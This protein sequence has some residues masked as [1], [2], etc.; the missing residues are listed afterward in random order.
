MKKF[1][2]PFVFFFFVVASIFICSSWENF[3]SVDNDTSFYSIPAGSPV[4]RYDQSNDQWQMYEPGV[5]FYPITSRYID[6]NAYLD[7][8][9]VATISDV[10]HYVEEYSLSYDQYKDFWGFPYSFPLSL[11]LFRAGQSSY[12]TYSANGY[13]DTLVS[14]LYSL[15]RNSVMLLGS[16]YMDSSGNL[17]ESSLFYNSAE[18]ASLGFLGIGT[19][20]GRD[21][22][23]SYT[24]LSSDG[25]IFGNGSVPYLRSLNDGLAGLG[26]L[27]TGA[28]SS[29]RTMSLYVPGSENGPLKYSGY[30]LL[31]FL[32]S[33]SE[34]ESRILTS[35]LPYLSSVGVTQNL[36]GYTMGLADLVAYGFNGL[37]HNLIGDM[38]EEGYTYTSFDYTDLDKSESI[39]YKNILELLAVSQTD[40][41]NLLAS[42][43][44]SHGTDMDIEIRHNMT[45]QADQFIEDFTSSSGK[46]TPSAGQ[47]GDVANVSG[48]LGDLGS[49][50]A[51]IADVFNQLSDDGNYSFFST[52]TQQELNPLLSRRLQNDDGY[53]DFLQPHVREFYSK[54]GSQW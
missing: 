50:D 47:I 16:S 32:I 9:D 49:N 51:S 25:K 20:L 31:S 12:V 48:G 53:I 2:I 19:L 54:V 3:Y 21:G 35:S 24:Y 39:Q 26:Y 42:Y 46:G 4:L 11:Q 14:Y 27:L 44:Y 37:S 1:T 29:A 40:I 23:P 38:Q 28:N 41:Q 17:A 34:N 18:V 6:F 8:L 13:Q 7:S 36:E 33:F 43:L 15:M 22:V 5:G 30:D 52:Q 45:A 10:Q